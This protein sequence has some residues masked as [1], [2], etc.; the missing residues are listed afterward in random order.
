MKQFMIFVFCLLAIGL[1][2]VTINVPDDYETIQEGID[3]AIDGD[4]VLVAAGTYQ[5]NINFNGK[6]ITV[7]SWY[8][9][10][11]D[12]SYISQTVI[13]GGEIDSVVRFENE[14]DSCSV[15][16]GFTVTNGN[17][18][19]DGGGGIKCFQSNPVLRNLH[20][21][22]NEGAGI[23]CY[24]SSPL[25]ENL[26]IRNNHAEYSGGGIICFNCDSEM[27]NIL[28]E[29]NTSK[30]AGGGIAMIYSCS[31]ILENVLIINNEARVG[32]GIYC[33]SHCYPVLINVSITGNRGREG[34]GG[35]FLCDSSV[36]Q[37]SSLERCSIY[38]NNSGSIRSGNEIY[39]QDSVAVILDTFTVLEPTEFHIS[40][41]ENFTFDIEAG[42]Y[43]QVSGDLYV[44]PDGDDSNS[45]M[46]EDEPL[47]TINYAS[48]I[49]QAD[50]LNH[51]TVYLA[52]GVY[53]LSQTGETFPLGFPSYV[54]LI[55]CGRDEV[56]LDAEY[57]GRLMDFNCQKGN[58][59]QGLTL[60]CGEG[61]TAGIAVIE[62][63]VVFDSIIVSNCE[64][65]F[66]GGIY[67]YKNCTV[68]ISNSIFRNNFVEYGVIVGCLSESRLLM[69]NVQISGNTINDGGLLS[70]VFSE[71]VFSKITITGNTINYGDDLLSFYDDDFHDG[72][73]FIINSIIWNNDPYQINSYEVP[74]AV[75]YCDLE[76][77]EEAIV[78][79]SIDWLEGNID[80]NPCFDETFHLSEDSPC[81]DAGTAYYEYEGEVLIDLSEDE[82]YGSA[83]DMGAFE[84]GMV[85]TDEFKIENVKCKISNYPNPFN[86]ET[87]IVFDLPEAGQ[88]KIAV[89]NLKGQLVKTLADDVLPAGK[90]FLIWDG[91]N[92]TGR[93]VS[94]GVYLLRMKNRERILNKKIMMMK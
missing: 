46:N 83:P 13:D 89:Y 31:P 14:E 41:L 91:R 29:N 33:E 27:H 34:A 71:S 61:Y 77:G 20:I 66:T 22:E 58:A 39:A 32:G 30:E 3:A 60:T 79:D 78:G 65:M 54:D 52:E 15:L 70:V 7:C 90:N 16:C 53:S 57:T 8:A 18:L 40:P 10:T 76:G 48:T 82:Y 55:G 74:L 88:V 4:S 68:E 23:N 9:T 84:Y 67:I 28:I 59:I 86:P 5:E 17:A 51:R 72:D 35:L 21:E 43:E 81:I 92:E 75:A 44:S 24:L 50:S 19:G 87:R 47:K 38:L 45:G 80:L 25:M 2:A 94:S 62:S 12:T 26:V 93:Q 42:Y 11:L 56:I 85:E 63:E 1:G 36:P 37:F 64:G 73:V 6:G 69:E 49:I